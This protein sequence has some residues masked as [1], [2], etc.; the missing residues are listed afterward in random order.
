MKSYGLNFIRFHSW[1][2]PDAAF[3]AADLEGIMVQAE[4]PQANVPAGSDPARDAVIEAEVKRM[5]DPYGNH[6]SFCLMTLGN[7]YGGKDELLS[8]WVDML[9]QRDSRHLYSSASA[10]QKT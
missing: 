2:P 3:A 7:E 10:S 6:P 9:I 5:G 1:G 8:R 4:G